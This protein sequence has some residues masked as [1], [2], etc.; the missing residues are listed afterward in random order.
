MKMPAVLNKNWTSCK[1]GDDICHPLFVVQSGVTR[2][3]VQVMCPLICP[4]V[5]V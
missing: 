5:V 1:P 4:N 2:V 3:H